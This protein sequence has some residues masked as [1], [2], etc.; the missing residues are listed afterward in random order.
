MVKLQM[1]IGGGVVFLKVCTQTEG[2][3]EGERLL[4]GGEWVKI[5]EKS[6][7][8]WIAPHTCI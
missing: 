8:Y 4:T 5:S 3:P 2:R 6:A 7:Y 1:L